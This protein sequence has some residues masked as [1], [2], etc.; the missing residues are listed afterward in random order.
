MSFT[1]LSSRFSVRVQ[2]LMFAT[3]VLS[4]APAA[5]ATA[6]TSCEGLS[7]LQLPNAEIAGAAT[8][9][10]G[11]F[12][13]STAPGGNPAA[14]ALFASLPALCRVTATL[15]PSSD[16]DI[17]IEVWLPVAGWNGKFQAVGNGG[18]AGVIPYTS[19]AAAVAGGYASAGTD[20]GHSGNTAAFAPGHPEKV[21]DMAYRAVHEM[22]VHAKAIIAAY[23]GDA[24][25]LSFWNSCSQGGRQGI[26]SAV[27]YPADFDGVVAGAPAVN[28]MHLNAGRIALNQAVNRTPAHAI[29]REKYAVVHAAVLD[30]CDGLDGVK[31]GVLEH[32]R[33][34][35]FDPQVLECKGADAANCLTAPQVEAARAFYAPVKHPA[36]GTVVIPGLERGTELSLGTLGGSQP[37]GNAVEAF[38]YVV[39]KDANWDWRRFN[40]AT[41]L[42][43]GDKAENGVLASTDPNLKPFFDRGGKLLI[44]HGWSDPQVLPG[45]TI[46][47]FNRGIDVAGREAVGTSMQ[48]YMV[49]GM[50]HCRGGVGTD[51][52]DAMGA[53][54]Q[55]VTSGQA[56]ARIT[57]S[58]IANGTVE[59]TRPLCPYGQV[60]T[61]DGTGSTNDAASFACVAETAMPASS[62]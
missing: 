43:L 10:A 41:D 59:R 12:H 58:R 6:A 27:R 25:K 35:R 9:A 55:W 5:P 57:A 62:R 42:E 56:P 22:T 23:Y 47:F 48:L 1:L 45:N 3:I 51:T 11:T 32:P 7:A 50:N 30:A 36:T 21:I 38:K 28:W 37:L 8:V 34:C 26:T 19:L 60:A 20:A 44:Y 53:I 13:P 61:W 40:L 4:L 15:K 33:A 31:D 52:F 18:W 14:A 39:F 17:R 49:P 2:V 29:P 46:D 54:E 24:P 16:S